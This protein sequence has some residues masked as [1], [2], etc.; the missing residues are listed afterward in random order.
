MHTGKPL[1]TIAQRRSRRPGGE[2]GHRK[3]AKH[4]GRRRKST[5]PRRG[6]LP[7]ARAWNRADPEKEK[8]LMPRMSTIS[9]IGIGALLSLILCGCSNSETGSAEPTDE[10]PNPQP[11]ASSAPTGSGETP[12]SEELEPCSLLSLSD[13][14]EF[15]SFQPPAEK[16]RRLRHCAFI[17]ERQN[18]SGRIPSIGVGFERAVSARPSTSDSVSRRRPSTAVKRH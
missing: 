4:P 14:E 18:G 16:D 11:S 8:Y 13:I 5:R 17:G 9:S 1:Q 6:E 3:I 12:D 15:G 2:H 7:G 10:P